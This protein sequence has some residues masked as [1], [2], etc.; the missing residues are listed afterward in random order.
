MVKQQIEAKRKKL[1]KLGAPSFGYTAGNSTE[2]G[3]AAKKSESDS[4]ISSKVEG[5]TE[6]FDLYLERKRMGLVTRRAPAATSSDSDGE[7]GF[8]N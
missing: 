3:A 2:T 7:L 6:L 1:E 8:R 5:M 4:G